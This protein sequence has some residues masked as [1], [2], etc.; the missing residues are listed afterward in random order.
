MSTIHDLEGRMISAE[1]LLEKADIT[2]VNK[3]LIR[4]FVEFKTA[5]GVKSHRQIKYYNTLRLLAVRHLD[6]KDF[7]ALTKESIISIVAKI[8]RSSLSEWTKHDYELVIKLF[9]R[10]LGRDDLVSWIKVKSPDGKTLP[11]DLATDE[12][13]QAMINEGVESARKVL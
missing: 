5:E 2:D 11:E 3:E 8:K 1:R 10:W 4:R 6:G 7:T 13:I 9:Y 12:D